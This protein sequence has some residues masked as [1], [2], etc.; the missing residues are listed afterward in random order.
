[1]VVPYP[2]WRR[3]AGAEI[4]KFSL[5]RLVQLAPDH[6]ARTAVGKVTFEILLLQGG[7][8]ERAGATL[9]DFS[10]SWNQGCG[11]NLV[12]RNCPISGPSISQKGWDPHLAYDA[13]NAS[14]SEPDPGSGAFLTP[15]SGI[16][17]PYF[18][19]F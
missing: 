6:L 2:L 3:Q 4:Q 7:K 5:G 13:Q 15:G 12:Y 11:S 8:A 18:P 19:Y 1:M 9:D 10:R 16:P 14:V 17:N